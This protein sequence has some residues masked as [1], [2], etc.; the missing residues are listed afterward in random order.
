MLMRAERKFLKRTATEGELQMKID[1]SILIWGSLL[2]VEAKA[3]GHPILL[4]LFGEALSVLRN[5]SFIL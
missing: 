1:I 4:W 2:Y 5:Y 3:R